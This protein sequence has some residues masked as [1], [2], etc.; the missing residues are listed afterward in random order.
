MSIE[1]WKTLS[2]PVNLMHAHEPRHTTLCGRRILRIQGPYASPSMTERSPAG[3]SFCR[4]CWKRVL[5]EGK[6]EGR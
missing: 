3:E 6:R 2:S 1:W 5:N 4:T